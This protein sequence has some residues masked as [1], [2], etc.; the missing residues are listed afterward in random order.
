MRPTRREITR[1]LKLFGNF[2]VVMNSE[3]RTGKYD[4]PGHTTWRGHEYLIVERRGDF[5]T[6]TEAERISV[7][8]G[9]VLSNFKPIFTRHGLFLFHRVTESETVYLLVGEQPEGSPDVGSFFPTDGI[10]IIKEGLI[11]GGLHITFS[12]E[13]AGRYETSGG[14][15]LSWQFY[16]LGSTLRIPRIPQRAIASFAKASQYVK[17]ETKATPSQNRK[18]RRKRITSQ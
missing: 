18:G 10:A 13:A 12:L 16:A 14:P 5:L 4:Q 11:L 2:R 15:G 17:K 7:S 9:N 8:G 3:S 1:K 6:I